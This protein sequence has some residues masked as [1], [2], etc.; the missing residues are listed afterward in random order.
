MSWLAIIVLAYFIMAII[1]LFDRYF[2]VGP[3]ADPRIY[4]FNIGFLW[5]LFS[6]FII[7]FGLHLPSLPFVLLGLSAG[8]VRFFGVLFLSLSVSRTEISRVVPII[9]SLQPIFSFLLFFPQSRSLALPQLL[10]FLLLILG[11]VLISFKK[12]G[13][14]SFNLENLKYPLIASLLYAC[15]FFLLKNAFLGTDFWSGIFLTLLGGGITA[16]MFLVVPENRKAVFS[17]ERTGKTSGLFIFSQGLAGVA[18]FLQYYAVFLAKP[19][20]VP[21]IN[22]LEGTRYVFLFFLVL[23]VSRWK[24]SVLKEE[25]SRETLILKAV[26]IV[27]ICLGL[28]LLNSK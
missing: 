19:G 20:Q 3:M 25:N 2:L 6:F 4:T 7:F 27:I 18:I 24:P 22:A 9:G 26:A 28:A 14:E 15:T 11:S 16:L 1:S 5:L 21:L 12:L 17:Q 13:K 10:A 23:L 8:F